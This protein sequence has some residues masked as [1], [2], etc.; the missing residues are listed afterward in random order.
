MKIRA[1]AMI[2][3]AGL[4]GLAGLVG[5]AAGA[6]G[7]TP[8]A[9]T[10]TNASGV[11]LG[12][13]T[14]N[15]QPA[16]AGDYVAA[17]DP[18]GNCAGATEVILNEGLAYFNLPIYGDDA[19]TAALDEGITGG[20]A[21][22]LRIWQAVTGAVGGHPDLDNP[23]TFSGW[24]NT[25][26]APMPDYGDPTVSYDFSVNVEVSILCP[27][28]T[29]VSGAVATPEWSPAGGELAG[30]GVTGVYWDP[31]AAG[32]GLHTLTYTYEATTAVCTVEVTA[33][34]DA[35]ILTEGPFCANGGP[36][37]LQAVTAGGT[38][39]GP[40]V[41]GGFFD[42]ST[43]APGEHNIAY[44]IESN[45]L[46]CAASDD[47]TVTIFPAPDVP[48]IVVQGGELVATNTGPAS[49][50]VAWQ[51]LFT[52]E[53]VATGVLFAEPQP[54]VS[55]VATVTNA[56][57]CTAVSLP[58]TFN[59]IGVEEVGAW[60]VW[61]DAEGQIHSSHPPTRTTV[62][63]PTG[64][65]LPAVQPGALNIVRLERNGAIRTLRVI[66]LQP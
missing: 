9:P 19:T 50:E 46:G 34:P 12:Q 17:F 32:E 21:Y 56:Y 13:A 59:P 10:P 35:T 65:I 38:W 48:L 63:D 25:N 23:T 37:P 45:D 49:N 47:I 55:Y 29:C 7:Q 30:P 28:S 11:M 39:S 54:G 33:T 60:R 20:E 18:Q 51:T 1:V 57:G 8:W 62:F 14:I 58:L 52:G 3:G 44:A 2:L 66:P 43:L 42:P 22:T 31:A 4:A 36:T 26:G 41:I 16:A 53:L 15:G 40:G 61:L 64:R 6:S 24:Q 5:L 27:P